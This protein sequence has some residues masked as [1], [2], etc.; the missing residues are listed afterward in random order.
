VTLFWQ[1]TGKIRDDYTVFLHAVD[2]RGRRWAQEDR[3]PN[4]GGYPTNVWAVGDVVIDRYWPAV[5][6][7]APPGEVQLLAGLYIWPAGQRLAVT[8]SG[9]DSVPLGR[10]EVTPAEKLTLRDRKP[11]HAI[12]RDFEAVRFL[13]YDDLP[14]QA[15]SG[16]IVGLNLY[17]QALSDVGSDRGWGLGLRSLGSP[18]EAR[19]VW[20][21]QPAVPTSR[22][23]KGNGVCTHH[24]VTLPPDTASG[25]YELTLALSD[26]TDPPLSLGTVHIV[27]QPRTFALPTLQHPLTAA[28][29]EAIRLLGYNLP[30]SHAVPGGSLPVTLYWQ[31]AGPLSADYTVFVHLLDGQERVQSQWDSAPAGGTRPTTGWLP[32]EVVSDTCTLALPP[33]LPPGTYR[34]EAG[35]YQPLTGKRLPVFQESAQ[36]LPGDRLLLDSPFEVSP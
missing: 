25:D 35:L 12:N 17:W 11:Q 20:N 18:G 29:G 3:R 1:A 33:T 13:G 15:V 34:L 4:Q 5:D 10:L 8:G 22:W 16:D 2:G 7:C 31:A 6:P 36:P 23:R 19:Q 24:D 14:A 21:G 26:R 28:F 9:L 30:Q 32:G 27:N